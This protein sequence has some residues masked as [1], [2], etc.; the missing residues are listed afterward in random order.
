MPLWYSASK[1]TVLRYINVFHIYH[2]A[3]T[4]GEPFLVPSVIEKIADT[5]IK[6]KIMVY[7]ISTTE[8]GT[9]LNNDGIRCIKAL[10]RLGEYIY[11]DVYPKLV[12]TDEEKDIPILVSISNSQYHAN[13]VQKAIEFYSSYANEYISVEDQGEHV[14][15]FKDENGNIIKHKDLPDEVWLV[16]DGR[17]K[18]NNLPAVKYMSNRHRIVMGE[19]VVTSTIDICANGNVCRFGEMS[20]IHSDDSAIL[21]QLTDIWRL[22]KI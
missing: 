6:N 21:K 10:N 16:K 9:I 2:L 3:F 8:N 19:D 1:L 22:L 7:H 13:D 11:N 4:G 14:T 17:A 15:P 20:F 12:E 18:D 5:I